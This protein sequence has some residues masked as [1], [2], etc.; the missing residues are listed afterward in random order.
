MKS[1]FKKIMLV[2]FSAL[3]VIS[4]SACTSKASAETIKDVPT[5]ELSETIL[6][7]EEF[8]FGMLFPADENVLNETIGL[9]FEKLDE[10][11][12]SEPTMIQSTTLYIAKVKSPDDIKEVKE[13]FTKKLELIQQSFEQYLPEPYEM[14]LK[15]Q[16]VD[17]GNYVMLVI[18]E[19]TD[20][21]IEMF[22]NELTE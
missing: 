20:K 13:A 2:L 4:I 8:Q 3:I 16:V 12:L 6:N 18:C 11:S 1:P 9:D 15:G 21:A 14:S 7:T 17:K 5:Q 10:Y 22:N 19:N